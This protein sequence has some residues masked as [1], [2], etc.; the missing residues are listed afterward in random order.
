[1]CFVV[2][3]TE[4]GGGF[5]TTDAGDGECVDFISYEATLFIKKLISFTILC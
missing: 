2:F 5:Y 1:M 3:L 4:D